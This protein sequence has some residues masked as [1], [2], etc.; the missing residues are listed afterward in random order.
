[1]DRGVR[2]NWKWGQEE[3]ENE[4]TTTSVAPGSLTVRTNEWSCFPFHSRRCVG[5]VDNFAIR[6]R[7]LS[8]WSLESDAGWVKQ[9][10]STFDLWAV[11]I[12]EIR[13]QTHN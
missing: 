10:V 1:V 6:L 3:N 7:I 8:I 12:V 5:G 2:Q 13:L 9:W 4:E 11:H